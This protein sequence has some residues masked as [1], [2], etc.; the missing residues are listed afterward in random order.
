MAAGGHQAPVWKLLFVV[1]L[2]FLSLLDFVVADFVVA[3][4]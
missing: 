1:C 3:D 4:Y 2:L